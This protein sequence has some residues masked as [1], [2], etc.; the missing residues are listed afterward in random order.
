MKI[1]MSIYSLNFILCV[2]LVAFLLPPS[3]GVCVGGHFNS[4]P[5][6]M[7]SMIHCAHLLHDV[8]GFL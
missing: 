3:M 4:W 8:H 2:G 5:L 1:S 7:M 6:Q